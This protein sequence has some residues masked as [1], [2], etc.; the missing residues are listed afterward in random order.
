M[1][2]ER[3]GMDEEGRGNVMGGEMEMDGRRRVDK[4]R[5]GGVEETG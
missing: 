4:D 5:N 1:R 2:S 3:K